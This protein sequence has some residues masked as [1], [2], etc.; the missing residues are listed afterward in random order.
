MRSFCLIL[1]LSLLAAASAM[2]TREYRESPED[3]TAY[4]G[5]YILL[6]AARNGEVGTRILSRGQR[7]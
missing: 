2:V 5:G 7:V 6:S 3:S 4:V 1:S